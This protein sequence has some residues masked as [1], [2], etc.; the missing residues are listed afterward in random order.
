MSDF[1]DVALKR[2]EE[3]VKGLCQSA[4]TKRFELREWIQ[5]ELKAVLITADLHET[6]ADGAI[7]D[8]IKESIVRLRA[9]DRRDL[10]TALTD[11]DDVID[12]VFNGGYDDAYSR[13]D[14]GCAGLVEIVR[15]LLEIRAF[16]GEM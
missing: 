2:D 4:R 16:I 6:V 12:D 15:N 3:L 5:L 9:I 7:L 8:G 10:P 13:L 11:Y 14:R 1:L